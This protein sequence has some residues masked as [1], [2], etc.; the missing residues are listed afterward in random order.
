LAETRFDQ[1][2]EVAMVTAPAPIHRHAP[3]AFAS[4]FLLA[5]LLGVAAVVAVIWLDV[6]ESSGVVRGSGVAAEQA[7]SV[8]PFTAVELAGDGVLTVHVGDKQAVTVT[9]DDNLIA[10][11][12]TDVRDDILVIET[13]GSFETRAPMGVDVVVPQLHAATLTGTGA[14]SVDGVNARRFE[15]DLP[16]DGMITVGGSVQRL[17]ANLSGTGEARLS[18]LVARDVVA[19]LSG[20]GRIQVHATHSLDASV[21][22]TGTI[23]YAGSPSKVTEEVTGVGT[24]LGR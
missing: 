6:G 23:E 24:I 7:R 18:E 5:L 11:V 16:G 13:K 22:G 8:A 15:V 19:S 21:P 1:K 14:V 17:D 4:G 10:R 9:A 12:T 20:T 3:R 2:E